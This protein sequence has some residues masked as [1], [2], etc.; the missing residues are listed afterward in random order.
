LKEWCLGLLVLAGMLA[1]SFGSLPK[2]LSTYL[3]FSLCT[4]A[5]QFASQ[6]FTIK[7]I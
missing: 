4:D 2:Q 7:K 3:T 1:I 6:K 5:E